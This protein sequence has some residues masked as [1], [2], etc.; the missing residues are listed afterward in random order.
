MGKRVFLAFFLILVMCSAVIG[1]VFVA[2]SLTQEI[3]PS[4]GP[5]GKPIVGDRP[6]WSGKINILVIGTDGSSKLTDTIILFQ[7][8]G[9]NKVIRSIPFPRDTRVPWGKG[10][11]KINALYASKDKEMA[12]MKMIK[13][14]T[15]LPIHYYVTIGLEGFRNFIDYLGGVEITVELAMKYKDPYQNLFIDIPAG[16]HHMNGKMA[17]QYVRFRKGSAGYDGSDVQRT[18]RQ[19]EFVKALIKQKLTLANITKAG[20]IFN[21]I[22]KYVQTNFTI[23]EV[24]DLALKVKG[25]DPSNFESYELSGHS[26]TISEISYYIFEKNKFDAD[27]LPNFR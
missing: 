15:G 12:T 24:S 4:F 2:T 1:G 23:S 20:D 10:H 22:K 19:Q 3:N 6:D 27:V 16:T 17:E 5:G 14:M 21:E 13:S 18:Q 25:F 26:Q 11:T 8:D 9:K 7:I